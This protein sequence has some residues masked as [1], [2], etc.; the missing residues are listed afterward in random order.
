MLGWFLV[1][2]RA[3]LEDGPAA[4]DPNVLAMWETAFTGVDWLEALVDNGEATCLSRHGYPNRFAVDAAQVLPFLRSRHAP[5]HYGMPVVGDDYVT[6]GGWSGP[7]T[8]YPERF[9]AITDDSPLWVDAWDQ[10]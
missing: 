8:T 4:K 9:A 2:R 10:S 1:V 3:G 7:M 6:P 5:L